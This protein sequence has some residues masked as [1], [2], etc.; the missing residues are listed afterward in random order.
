[1]IIN[2]PLNSKLQY[3]QDM[4]FSKPDNARQINRLK[5]LNVLRRERL[6]RAELSR[7]LLISKVSIS[8]IVDSL[9]KDGLV[10]NA[11]LYRSTTGR[12]ATK[13]QINKNAGR[14]FAVEIRKSNISVSISD[15]LGR[16]MR[17]ER[18][19][20]TDN[21]WED[22]E[23]TINKLALGNRIYG[24][25]FVLSEELEFPKLPFNYT[26]ATAAEAQAIAEINAAATT[27]EDFYFVSWGDN[28]EANYYHHGLIAIDTFA[29]IRVAKDIPC[30]CGG[31]GCLNAVAS[32]EY[33]KGRTGLSS[34]K[35]I[36]N[37]KE[38]LDSTKNMA[39]ALSEAVQA[40]GAKAVMLTGEL[41]ML[42]DEAYANM[43]TRLSMLLPP[44]RDQVFIYRSQCGD[45]GNREGAGIIALDRFF[46]HPNLIDSLNMLE[47]EIIC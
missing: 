13:L 29:H 47:K 26:M 12:P 19:P 15:M 32:G 33:I 28:I 9:I 8:E 34:Y 11:E 6:S 1:M 44:D 30:S 46:Y 3:H 36:V 22:I 18:F 2:L 7:E 38:V 23:S 41:S 27:M 10:E 25:C 37:T 40:T 24:V 14:A 20:R 31:N 5:I 17:F 4:D 43:Q 16:P 35:E 42:P 21:M 45:R 39:F